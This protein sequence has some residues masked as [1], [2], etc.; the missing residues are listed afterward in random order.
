[1]NT[2]SP[3]GTTNLKDW[4]AIVWLCLHGLIGAVLV[5]LVDFIAGH[6]FGSINWAIQIFGSGISAYL[7]QKYQGV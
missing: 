5:F 2:G 7:H 3:S 6:D 4:K 1:M